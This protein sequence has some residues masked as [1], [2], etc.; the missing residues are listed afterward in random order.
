MMRLIAVKLG[1]TGICSGHFCVTFLVIV[2]IFSPSFVL[3]LL[4]ARQ[5]RVRKCSVSQALS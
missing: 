4:S 5:E 2:I 1:K 3:H